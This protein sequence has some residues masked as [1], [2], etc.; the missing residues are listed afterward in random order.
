MT[1]RENCLKENGNCGCPDQSAQGAQT[2]Q[3]MRSFFFFLFG[4]NAHAWI[5]LRMRESLIWARSLRPNFL[6]STS[7]LT[8][9][10]SNV[11]KINSPNLVFSEKNM[12]LWKCK[13][14]RSCGASISMSCIHYHS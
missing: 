14:V 10:Q 4:R 5:R 3:D 13:A 6:S 1:L 9:D 8:N 7:I 11:K 2:D 12:I